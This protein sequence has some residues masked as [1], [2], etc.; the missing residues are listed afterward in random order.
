MFRV[1]QHTATPSCARR[2]KG[3]TMRAPRAQPLAANSRLSSAAVEHRTR[4]A[5]ALP[6]EES[7]KEAC[8]LRD[9]PP[10][11]LRVRVVKKGVREM[12]LACAITG[13]GSA[14]PRGFPLP[15]RAKPPSR[16]AE[17]KPKERT[18]T[19]TKAAKVS[20]PASIPPRRRRAQDRDRDQRLARARG[21]SPNAPSQFRAHFLSD[22]AADADRRAA[23]RETLDFS[24]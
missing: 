3:L 4:R 14:S 12:W 8:T 24:A 15:P 23:R 11:L 2:V 16:D 19:R 7:R 10:A 18:K 22:R 21:F 1:K 17:R 9:G 5:R 13:R 6:Q 20:R